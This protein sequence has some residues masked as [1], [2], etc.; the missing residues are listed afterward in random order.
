[1]PVCKKKMTLIV[2]ILVCVVSGGEVMGEVESRTVA[3]TREAA[4]GTRAIWGEFGN[5]TINN[6]GQTGFMGRLTGI[7]V[8]DANDYGIWLEDGGI[9]QFVVREGDGASDVDDGAYYRN[10]NLPRINSEGQVFFS[11]ELIGENVIDETNRGLWRY[12]EGHGT[13]MLARRGHPSGGDIES[14]G[15]ISYARVND[16]GQFAY[17]AIQYLDNFETDA[18]AIMRGEGM[19]QHVIV[20]NGEHATDLGDEVVF[21]SSVYTPSMNNVGGLGFIAR[22]EGPGITNENHN[23]IWYGDTNGH[24]LITRQGF[25]ANGTDQWFNEFGSIRVNDAGQVAFNASL[26]PKVGQEYHPF[27]D[28][29]LWAGTSDLLEM[30]MRSGDDAAGLNG[31]QYGQTLSFVMNTDGDVLYSSWLLFDG[32]ELNSE[33]GMWLH[34]DGESELIAVTGRSLPGLQEWETVDYIFSMNMND[35]GQVVFTTTVEGDGVT[36]DNDRALWLRNA[37]GGLHLLLREG[38]LFD[39]DDDAVGEDLRMINDIDMYGYSGG[40]DG[41]TQSLNDS[42]ELAVHLKFND[43]SEG[44]FVLDT[45]S[46]IPEPMTVGLMSAGGLGF[47]LRRRRR[48]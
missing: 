30:V 13:N 16:A 41:Q 43:G 19:V 22:I 33:K 36:D 48:E 8:V 21:A 35:L 46:T 6:A 20:D 28:R 31:L 47:L 37:D 25:A 39:V 3:L 2:G 1:M 12:R 27:T 17:R 14:T 5:F 26:K 7:G 29:G 4:P 9:K 34:S 45:M 15:S 32:V 23:G 38:E 40:E 24:E 18:F 11:A 10:F 42:G 44:L